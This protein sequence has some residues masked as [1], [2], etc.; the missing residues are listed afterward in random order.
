MKQHRDRV[1]E[2][3]EDNGSRFSSSWSILS[4]LIELETVLL[5]PKNIHGKKKH[6]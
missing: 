4:R 2:D 5:L 1:V 6:D 3:A